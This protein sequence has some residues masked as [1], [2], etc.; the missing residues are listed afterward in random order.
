MPPPKVYGRA[1]A[2]AA[3]SMCAM[4]RASLCQRRAG[5]SVSPMGAAM[6]EDRIAVLV[7]LVVVR[8]AVELGARVVLGAAAAAVEPGAVL[9][10]GFGELGAVRAVVL[11]VEGASWGCLRRKRETRESAISASGRIKR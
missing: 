8:A 11:E 1:Q 5:G 2:D 9:G 6:S 4:R 3:V 7:A 10:A